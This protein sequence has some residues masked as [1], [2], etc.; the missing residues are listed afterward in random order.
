VPRVTKKAHVQQYVRQAGWHC[1][2]RAE[3]GGLRAQFPETS[4]TSVRGALQQMGI[5]VEQP[6]AGVGTKTLDEL[7]ASLIS[8]AAAYELVP[9]ECRS[10]VIAAKDRARF[11]SLNGKASLEK[12]ALKGEMVEWML[13]WLGDPGMF[14]A[15]VGLRKVQINGTVHGPALL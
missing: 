9:V 11:A 2:G 4:E 14:G 6:F 5:P 13:V 7:E 1:V 15:W 3:W 10:M 8:M 12:R